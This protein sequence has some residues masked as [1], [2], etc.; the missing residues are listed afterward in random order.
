MGVDFIRGPCF[1]RIIA[2]VSG[3]QS[4]FPV[5]NNSGAA[6]S[7]RREI[8][9]RTT[10]E[11]S[12]HQEIRTNTTGKS[13][14]R[15]FVDTSSTRSR[16]EI[17]SQTHSIDRILLSTP[18]IP[19][20]NGQEFALTTRSIPPRR[21]EAANQLHRQDILAVSPTLPR[22][23]AVA[24]PSFF[25]PRRISRCAAQSLPPHDPTGHRAL[26]RSAIFLYMK[27][28]LRI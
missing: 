21:L 20:G 8:Y 23:G 25:P 16:R 15:R 3:L 14:S 13:M 17:P 26:P 27:T 1:A 7:P 4:H 12:G 28:T 22:P 5:R 9:L 11:R 6:A 18:T 24:R 19:A 10:A 2:A